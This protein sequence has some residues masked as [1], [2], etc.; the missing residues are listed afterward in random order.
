M[1]ENNAEKIPVLEN[2]RLKK[3]KE[4]IEG[5]DGLEV[6]ETEEGLKIDFSKE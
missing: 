3:I 2:D 1:E 4:D 5:I 6:E